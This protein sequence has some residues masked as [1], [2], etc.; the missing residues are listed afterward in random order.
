[1]RRFKDK[2]FFIYRLIFGLFSF[3]KSLRHKNRFSHGRA[4]TESISSNTVLYS[5][6]TLFPKSRWSRATR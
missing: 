4:M 1:M 2:Y 6:F 5:V 3:V